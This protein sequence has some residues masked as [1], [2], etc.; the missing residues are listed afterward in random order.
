VLWND[1][2]LT[3]APVNYTVSPASGIMV[4]SL[5]SLEFVKSLTAGYGTDSSTFTGGR[6]LQKEDVEHPAAGKS[7]PDYEEAVAGLVT[8]LSTGEVKTL[9]DARAFLNDFGISAAVSL[10]VIRGI[11]GKHKEF[12]E[13]LPMAEKKKGNLFADIIESIK[14]SMGGGTMEKG[15]KGDDDDPEDQNAGGNNAGE[16]EDEEEEDL[17]NAEEVIKALADKVE[18]LENGQQ[19]IAKALKTLT[20]HAAQDAA[21]KKSMG[22]GMIALMENYGEIAKQ[23]LPRRG[24]GGL[25]AAVLAKGNAGG[26]QAAKKH[27]QFTAKDRDE[28]IPVLTKAVADKEMDIVDC[29]KLETQI[30]KSI[31]DPNFQIDPKFVSFLETKLA[32]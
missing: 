21:F 18:E 16:D 30:N 12:M 31:R 15:G 28:L 5:S 7:G 4:K 10:D 3:I 9:E 27:R 22:E 32:K 1:L 13:V 17:I 25:D 29:G 26:G 14:K 6:A 24:I 23:P 11:A 20:D 2:A 19:E 8:A